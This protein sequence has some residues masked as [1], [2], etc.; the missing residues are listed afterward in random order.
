MA[1]IRDA[2][3]AQRL[4]EAMG[5]GGLKAVLAWYPEDIVMAC[6]TW[7]CLGLTVCLYPADGQPVF[8]AAEN[9]PDDVLPPG[10][11]HRRFA[12]SPEGRKDLA[13][14]LAQDLGR[15]GIEPGQLGVPADDGQHATTT[16]PGETSP[17]TA[18]VIGTL[19]GDVKP[20]DATAVFTVAGSRKTRREVEALRRTNA[21]AAAGLRAFHEALVPGATEVGVAARVEAAIHEFS[22]RQGCAL[23]RGWAHVQGGANIYDSGTFS[24]S[25]ALALAEGDLVLIELATCVDGYW[26][27]L[28]RTA[29][30]GRLGERQRALLAA[31]KESQAAA[32]T[33]ARPG[34]TH[35]AVEAA[36]RA[37]LNAKGYGGGY[38]N[39]CGHHV[40]FRYHDRGP[41]LVAGS[42]SPLEEGMVITVEP[43]AYGRQFGGGA[44][45]EDDVLVTATGSEVISPIDESWK[46]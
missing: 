27:D 6:G 45:F 14:L 8:Y 23:A 40:G 34:V 15:L 1:E 46:P 18:A 20:R 25:S 42:A 24:R 41:V 19:L 7:P 39:F 32:I 26:S 21:A 3:R 44:R 12:P 10:F 17:F 22:G 28:T 35:E 5:R 29:G 16:F 9:E 43:G 4:R 33:A 11:Q 2:E 31:V 36:A 13:R 30:V 38:P 37:V